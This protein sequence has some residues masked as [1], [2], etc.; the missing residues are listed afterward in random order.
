MGS[1][2]F[3]LDD[4]SLAAHGGKGA[5][6]ARLTLAGFDVPAWFIISTDHYR[7][8]VTSNALEPTI[9]TALAGLD[10]T[11]P[12]ALESASATIRD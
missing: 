9:T 6:L 8:Y 7:D 1:T 2:S 5:N 12:G 10:G 3:S 11:D 4:I